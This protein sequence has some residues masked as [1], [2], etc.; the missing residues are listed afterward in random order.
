[1]IK[2]RKR[3]WF[4][5]AIPLVAGLAMLALALGEAARKG[6]TI[7]NRSGQPIF[8]LEVSRGGETSTFD[9]IPPGGKVTAVPKAGGPFQVTGRMPMGLINGRFG[10]LG[11]RVDLEILPD[12]TVKPR[13]E[14]R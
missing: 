7:E 13:S 12:G 8:H 4:R 2:G 9:N 5:L 6:V 14:K 10:D 3:W 11:P 1:M